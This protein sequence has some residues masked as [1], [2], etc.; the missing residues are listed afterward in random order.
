[1]CLLITCLD[2][3]SPCLSTLVHRTTSIDFLGCANHHDML[4]QKHFTAT[5]VLGNSHIYSSLT[6]NCDIMEWFRSLIQSMLL[7]WAINSYI[8]VILIIYHF[9][10]ELFTGIFTFSTKGTIIYLLTHQLH[11]TDAFSFPFGP[12]M[13]IGS[14]QRIT[15]HWY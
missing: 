8:V 7:S 9:L 15:N 4:H 11:P 3:G 12:T 14:T 10:E 5:N 6:E 1:M 2:S 13:A